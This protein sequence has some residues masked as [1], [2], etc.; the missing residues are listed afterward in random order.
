MTD[1]ELRRLSRADL[2]DVIYELEKKNLDYQQ[3]IQKLQEALDEKILKLSSAGSIAEAALKLNGVFEAAQ[4]A[5]DQYVASLQAACAE[6][7][8]GRAEITDAGADPE[9]DTQEGTNGQ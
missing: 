8:Q 4:A 7:R 1:K 6:A 3:Q 9:K 5:A 2:I